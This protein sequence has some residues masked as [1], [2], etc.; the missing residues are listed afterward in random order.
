MGNS[1]SLSSLPYTI[2]DEIEDPSRQGS[3]G[4]SIHSGKRK[5]DGLPVC[6]F[7]GSKPKLLQTPVSR[8]FPAGGASISIGPKDR[9]DPNSLL[10]PA[11]KHFQKSKTLVHPNL[12]K[13]YATLDTDA[14]ADAA[15]ASGGVPSS[16]YANT[17]TGGDL[18]IVT[19]EVTPLLKWMQQ[20]E[21]AANN[22]ADQI[23]W[24]LVGIIQA[25]GFLH[26]VRFACY[27]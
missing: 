20:R 10:I 3:Y 6:V 13:V 5:S 1:A 23:A 9:V 4:W 14:P 19:E 11:F 7:K 21:G 16:P 27:N 18:I 25:L 17:G 8:Y 15:P 24:G 26:S 22:T 12:L 2:G